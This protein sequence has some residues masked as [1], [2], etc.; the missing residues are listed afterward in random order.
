MTR[1]FAADFVLVQNYE[2]ETVTAELPSEI[3]G[4]EVEDHARE[5]VI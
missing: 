3:E 5:S 4:I 2:I 1:E